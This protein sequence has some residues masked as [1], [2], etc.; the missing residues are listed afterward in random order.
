MLN[1]RLQNILDRTPRAFFWIFAA[2]ISLPFFL[3]TARA[4]E[5]AKPSPT[6]LP[7]VTKVTGLIKLGETVEV[8][9]D[10][11]KEWAQ[12][13][14]NDSSKLVLYLDGTL[15][16]GLAPIVDKAN[17]NHL[18]FKLER[19]SGNDESKA[20]NS[21]AWYAWFSRPKS[22]GKRGTVRVH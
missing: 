7:K 20:D 21:K 4:E 1:T 14:T 8:D 6:P 12:T 2:A 22:I 3:S 10:G 9:C 5:P 15:M 19:L 18:F 13:K 11:L 17:E 16:K